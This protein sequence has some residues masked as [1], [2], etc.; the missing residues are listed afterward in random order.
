MN[1]K[2]GLFYFIFFKTNIITEIIHDVRNPS[3]Y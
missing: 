1:E 2:F 3:F